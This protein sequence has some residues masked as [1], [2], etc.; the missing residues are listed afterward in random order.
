VSVHPDS[1]RVEDGRAVTAKCLA[2]GHLVQGRL[3]MAEAGLRW[4][5]GA[6]ER[7][8][9]LRGRG[10]ALHSL[11]LLAWQKQDLEAADMLLAESENLL[12]R[13]RDQQSLAVVRYTQACLS[14]QRG[15]WD[16]AVELYREGLA[17]TQ[18]SQAIHIRAL[19][20]EALGALLGAGNDAGHSEGAFLL[21]Y[22][23][24]IYDGLNRTDDV[25][26]TRQRMARAYS[27]PPSVQAMR[28]V[29]YDLDEG[30]NGQG[31]A[32]PNDRRRTTE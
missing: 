27:D 30:P 18:V 24:A 22:A 28:A 16:E 17:M 9:D 29:I 13:V 15:A 8:E 3:D 26:R 1:D 31:F 21:R 2:D 5:A 25:G 4:S 23:E 6:F 11:A 7:L 20:A 32:I 12:D 10:A 14:E 19:L